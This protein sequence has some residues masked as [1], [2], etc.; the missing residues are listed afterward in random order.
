MLAASL[1][2][3][4]YATVFLAPWVLIGYV[5]F[6]VARRVWRRRKATQAEAAKA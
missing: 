5:A 4:V 3:I 2:G 1:A 6:L